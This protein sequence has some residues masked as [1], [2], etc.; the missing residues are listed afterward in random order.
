MYFDVGGK[1]LERHEQLGTC[2]LLRDEQFHVAYQG[3]MPR[4]PGR[5]YNSGRSQGR[6]SGFRERHP[7]RAPVTSS[8]EGTTCCSSSSHFCPVSFQRPPNFSFGGSQAAEH[9]EMEPHRRNDSGWMRD[10]SRRRAKTLCRVPGGGKEG[11][12]EKGKSLLSWKWKFKSV[13]GGGKQWF[14]HS[15]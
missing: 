14:L 4:Y 1:R 8:Y 6:L 2:G 10:A 11:G 15:E 12:A 13:E 7:D 5:G 3:N 9:R